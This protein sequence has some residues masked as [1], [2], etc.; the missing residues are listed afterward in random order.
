MKLSDPRLTSLAP[1]IGSALL[2]LL[3]ILIAACMKSGSGG[4]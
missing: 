1:K 4:Y 2:L 3:P